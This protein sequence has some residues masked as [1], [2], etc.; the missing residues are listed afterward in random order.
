V[1]DFALEMAGITQLFILIQ[2]YCKVLECNQLILLA[3]TH[4]VV[5]VAALGTFFLLEHAF[6]SSHW[7]QQFS[8]TH[9]SHTF[10][11]RA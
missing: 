6:F 1:R 11:Q 8:Y 9:E 2:I 4:M 7:M 3:G 5:H 10:Q